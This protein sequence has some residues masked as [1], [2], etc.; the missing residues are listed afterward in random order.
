MAVYKSL[1]FFFL[2][3]VPVIG[4]GIA[5]PLQAA[6]NDRGDVNA[7]DRGLMFPYSKGLDVTS[8][9]FQ[10]LTI[11]APF[12]LAAVTPKSDWLGLTLMYAES[13]ALVFGASTLVKLLVERDRPYTYFDGAPDANN[14]N[15]SFFSRHT[16][17]AFNGAAFTSVVFTHYFPDSPW[18]PWVWVGT[19]GLATATGILRIAGGSHFLSDVLVGAVVGGAIGF[20]VPWLQF[21]YGKHW[22]EKGGPVLTVS[23]GEV[24]L[25]FFR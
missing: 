9:V 20:L 6:Q 21:R 11:A 13:A 4:L 23:P 5:S 22:K 18:T 1:R 25:T 17:M 16:T 19:F 12:A 14:A 7:F 8:D 2:I 15:Q 10:Y 3:V 24:R